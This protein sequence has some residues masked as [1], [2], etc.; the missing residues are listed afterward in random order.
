[1]IGSC[2]EL[3]CKKF[4]PQNKFQ[5]HKLL[6]WVLSFFKSEMFWL[7]FP[8]IVQLVK[9]LVYTFTI[10]CRQLCVSADYRESSKKRVFEGVELRMNG[11]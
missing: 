6:P 7:S 5:V 10:A 4:Q 3:L 11:L 8:V 2:E 9:I 1:M